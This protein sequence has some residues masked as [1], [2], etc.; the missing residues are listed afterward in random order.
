[1]SSKTINLDSVTEAKLKVILQKMKYRNVQ[2]FLL[3]IV[4][5]K[6][7]QLK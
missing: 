4:E 7:S 3:A 1:M 6:Y 5:E 2:D